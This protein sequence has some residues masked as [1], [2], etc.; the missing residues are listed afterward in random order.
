MWDG[1]AEGGVS[2][3]VRP[4]KNVAVVLG[5]DGDG[6]WVTVVMVEVVAL[7]LLMGVRRE[8]HG[9]VEGVLDG[10]SMG[11]PSRLP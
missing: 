5:G 8:L 7:W 2:M 1:V 6:R 10:A 4:D 3:E 11:E 9:V